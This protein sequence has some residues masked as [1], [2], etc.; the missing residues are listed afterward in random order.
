MNKKDVSKRGVAGVEEEIV[1]GA[2]PIELSRFLKFAGLFESGGEAKHAIQGGAVRVDG[3]VEKV[4]R[5]QLAAGARVE[6][7]GRV[8]VVK[9]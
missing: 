6:C 9:V 3:A 4:V 8:L 7:A 2:A 1:I 5:K